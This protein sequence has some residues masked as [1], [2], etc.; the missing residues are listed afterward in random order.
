MTTPLWILAGAALLLAVAIVRVAR[1]GR[2]RARAR[3]RDAWGTPAARPHKMDAILASHRS[4]AAAF[5][6]TC[7]DD[8]TW[9]DLNLD[10]IFESC[11]RTE[12]TLGQ[13]A[14]YHRLRGAPTGAH[15]DAFEAI[16]TRFTE[17]ADARERAQLALARLQDPHG[18]D[19]WWVG[20]PDVIE[21]RPWHVVFPLIGLTAL[22]LAVVLPFRPGLLPLLPVVVVLSLVIRWAT[23]RQVLEMAA[24]F[25]QFAPIIA[26]GQ[27]LAFLDDAAIA[28]IAAPLR[29]EAPRLT[30]LKTIARW[31]S[32][33]PFMLSV[34]PGAVAMLATDLASVV[35][36]YLNLVFLLDANGVYFGARELRTNGPALLR[37]IQ[38][39]GDVDAAISVASW[40]AGLPVWTRPCVR[41][42]GSA[43]A[44]TEVRHPLVA[45]AV[46]SSI[47]MA[48]GRGVLVT[49]SNMSGKSTLLRT[50]GVNAVL[51]Q[52]LG[53]C[54]ATEYAAPILHV[55]SCIGRADDLIAGKSYY[56]VE[57]E[58]LVTLM[59]ASESEAPHLFLLDE[60]FRGT[61]AVERIAAG[62]AVLRE[63]VGTDGAPRHIVMAATHDG[64]LVDLLP[65]LFAAVHFSDRL[66]DDGLVFDYRLLPG[67]ATTRNA[68]ALLAQNGAPARVV[69]RAAACAADLDAARRR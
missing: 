36:D 53:T 59:R 10:A 9:A 24:A 35:Y 1:S 28:P 17:D 15:L 19:L 44:L 63:L 26:T 25:R 54:L 20:R 41:P 69:E 27:A 30:R 58:S 42:P 55:R 31:V 50:V 64:E 57:V 68:I 40:R 32:G 3:L 43:A 13:H 37:V 22:A 34:R 14:L 23:D 33:D 62:Q 16:V 39:A 61:N 38:A 49:G 12:S 66:G 47:T 56:L 7:L 5:G 6:D 18:Y 51:A 60:M 45:D 48:A 8:R 67:R 4:R 52:T 2:L 11:D 21:S 46:P 29:T 65:D